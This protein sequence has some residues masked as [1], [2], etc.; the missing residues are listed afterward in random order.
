MGRGVVSL[1]RSRRET[2]LCQT[3]SPDPVVTCCTHR[4]CDPLAEDG[5]QE[6]C[7]DRRGEVAGD[8]LDVV[9]ELAAVGALDDGDPEDADDDQEH[10]KHSARRAQGAVRC[11]RGGGARGGVQGMLGNRGEGVDAWLLHQRMSGP[12]SQMLKSRILNS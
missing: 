1:P 5:Q 6:Q 12:E 7:S 10:H 4:L 3:S 8:G 9:E 11:T 2:R